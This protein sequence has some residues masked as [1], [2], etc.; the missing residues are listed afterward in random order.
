MYIHIDLTPNVAKPNFFISCML[1]TFG[2]EIDI[3]ETIVQSI[4]FYFLLIIH[5]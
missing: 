1:K 4:R 5:I 2:F 3:Y